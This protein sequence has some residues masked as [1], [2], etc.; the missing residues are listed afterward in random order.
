VRPFVDTN[1]LVYAHDRDEPHKQATAHRVLDEHAHDLVVSTQVLTEF[2]VATT[3]KLARPLDPERATRQVDELGRGTVVS[4]DV[5]LVRAAIAL[6]RDRQLSLWDAL[7]VRAAQRGGCDTVL[8]ED[9][10]DGAMFDG[11]VIRNPF[12]T[13]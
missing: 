2:Y 8:T 7:I 1:V 10:Q 5:D 13:D 6:S 11:I 12:R 9:L 3:R 4:V